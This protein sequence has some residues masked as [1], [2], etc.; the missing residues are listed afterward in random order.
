MAVD[1]PMEPSNIL[2][3]P[4]ELSDSM[5]ITIED[6][7]DPTETEQA[8]GSIV[9]D[10]GGIEMGEEDPTGEHDDNLTEY[11]DDATLQS[12]A[13]DLIESFNGD[14][15]SR[16][17][18]VQAYIKGLDLL[19]MKVEERTQPWNGASGVYHPMMTEAVIRFQA[20]AMSELMP[21]SGPARTKIMGKI[22][23]DRTKQAQRVENELNYLITEEM[24]D[25]RDEMEQLLFK[26]PL[27]GS[28]FKKIYFDPLLERPVSLFVPAEDFVVSYGS[29]N[30]R[31]TPRFTHVMKKTAE[32]ILALQVSGFYRE[33][34]LPEPARDFSDIEEKYNEMEG[35]EHVVSDDERHTIL[36]MH[37][38]IDLPDQFAD[39]QGLARP[40]V[41]T[42]D[43]SSSTILSI[44]RNWYEDDAKK[45][46]RMHFVHYPYL[47]G[48][49]F[50]GTGLIHTI[51]GLTKSA[52]SIMRQ[53][54]DAGTLSNLPAGFKTRGLRIKGDNTPIM[55]GE[56]R[57]VD[58][59]GG[60]IKDSI[61]P[62]PY[63]EPS[64]VLM[65]LMQNVVEEGRRIGSVG[66]IQVGDMNA[67]APVGTTLALMERSMKV[68]S[69]IQ[70]RL[71]AAMKQ[72]LRILARI[73]HDYMPAEYSYELEEPANRVED[74]GSKVDVIP[75]SDPNAST[76]A[77][78]IMQYQ[79][80]LQLAQGAPQLYD[81]GKLHQQMLS[82]MG[83]QDASD[84]IKL[85][86]DIKPR[87]PVTENMAILKQEPVK[88]FAYQDHEAHI[89]THMMAMNDPKIQQIV[90]QSPFAAAIQSAMMSHITEH[91][92]LQYRVEIQKQLGVELP[93]PEAPMP[94]DIEL[95][96]SRLVAQAATKL[97]QK[98]QAE[99]AA[100]QAAAQQADPLTQIQQR[101]LAIKEKE[102][103]HNMEMDKLRFEL[104]R[105]TKEANALV[106]ADR[107]DAERERAAANMSVKAAELDQKTKV[108]TA[109]TILE[110]AKGLSE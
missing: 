108:D 21:A 40:Y 99:A 65:A 12:I 47:P 74:F 26:L 86:D 17:E 5:D 60:T 79:A 61:V 53:L 63:K 91:V 37:V 22:T 27:A 48:M 31:T 62:L 89:Q 10:F 102:L 69:G 13:S 72:E 42:L 7:Q 59:A 46:K 103:Q 39:P 95:Q 68:M 20:Q 97:F 11:L 19:G 70:A 44:R 78:R 15:S 1:K 90:G 85:P 33:V 75:V 80:A 66:D 64:Q 105:V 52:T 73:V 28:A 110:M 94:E 50:Y 23:T 25:Y 6:I 32:E 101:E 81:M 77:Q 43:K 14:R 54:I 106:Q 30:L 9:V 67:Q 56:F 98:D 35:T 100:Q 45:Q 92:A 82:V 84:I 18:W 29:S 36:E 4:D 3:Q 107:V 16:K 71:H 76:M 34:D 87:D 109:R 88:A 51:G 2:L 41:I 49:G 57:D 8:D 83:I 58:V 55:P 93:D 24:P 104:D 96:V 38:D